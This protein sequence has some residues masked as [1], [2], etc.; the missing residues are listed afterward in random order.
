MHDFDWFSAF[1]KSPEYYFMKDHPIVYFC[2]EFALDDSIPTY[3]GGLGILAGDIIREASEQEIP[4]VTVGLYYREGYVHH[5]LYPDGILIK[6]SAVLPESNP[7]L[8]PVVD[9]HNN[10]VI[11]TVPIQ[12]TLVYVQAWSYMIETVRVF[13]LDTDLPQNGEEDRHI[14]DQLYTSSHDTRFKQEIILGLGGLRLLEALEIDPIGFH[15]NEG[16]SALLALEIARLEMRKHSQTFAQELE[17]TRQHIF[18]TNHTLTPAGNDTYTADLAL[19]LLA[20]FAKEIQVPASEI[21]QMGLLAQSSIFSMTLLALR[22]AGKI[23]AV[24]KLHAEIAG[25]IWKSYPM[26]PI[27]NGIHIKTWDGVG[28]KDRIWEKHRENK[29]LLLEYIRSK[30]GVSWDENT[31]LLGWGRRMVGYKR[32]LALFDTIDQFKQLATSSDKPINVVISGVVHESDAEGLDILK[33]IQKIVNDDLKGT[34]VYLPKYTMSLSKLMVAGCDV[35]LNTPVVGFE[36]CGTSGMKAALNGVL[37]ASTAD[38]WVA[39]ANLFEVGWLLKNDNLSED[40]LSVLKNNIL[41]TYYDRDSDGVSPQWVKMM[42]N[43]RDMTVNQF[44]TATM[45]RKYIEE[46]YLSTIQHHQEKETRTFGIINAHG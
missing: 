1:R 35:W 40:I 5:D 30:T 46:F 34:V 16:H 14:T 6:S 9:D 13:L 31:L 21:V 19:T 2:A 10:R 11:I 18:F 45:L 23:N 17:N 39:E 37:P 20:G 8:K 4:L 36:A 42:K 32:P 22:M 44:D 28:I 43:A 3:A 15:L 12:E 29:R 33:R 38:G 7:R 24:S 25:K 26:V 41:P 27:T